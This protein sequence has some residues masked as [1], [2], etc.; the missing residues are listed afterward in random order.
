MSDDKDR[1]NTMSNVIRF[2]AA[3][4]PADAAAWVSRF[5]EGALHDLALENLMDTWGRKNSTEA[6]QWLNQ[7]PAG[8]SRNIAANALAHSAK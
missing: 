6:S 5:P 1:D 4:A 8:H 7:L 2:W 3:S